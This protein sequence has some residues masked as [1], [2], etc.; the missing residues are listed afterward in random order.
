MQHT[1][2]SHIHGRWPRS[3]FCVSCPLLHTP[4]SIRI[5]TDGGI[6]SLPPTIFHIP[7][8]S[9]RIPV[10]LFHIPFAL[11]RRALFFYYLSRSPHPPPPVKKPAIVRSTECPIHRSVG[12][13]YSV[14]PLGK[15][16][17]GAIM[18]LPFL[19]KSKPKSNSKTK[20]VW[21]TGK[22]DHRIQTHLTR[23]GFWREI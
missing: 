21:Q 8:R 17:D 9:K 23:K 14:I 3:F 13:P 20:R 15:D 22:P 4:S 2:E 6:V 1:Q 10:A 12:P 5:G 11:R 16:K 18:H 19:S 7:P